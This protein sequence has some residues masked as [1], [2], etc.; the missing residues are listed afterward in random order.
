MTT[1]CSDCKGR[2]TINTTPSQEQIKIENPYV[3]IQAVKSLAKKNHSIDQI[4]FGLIARYPRH[5]KYITNSPMTHIEQHGSIFVGETE[6]FLK[7]N[8]ED[9]PIQT[10]ILCA[11]STK[12]LC[13]LVVGVGATIRPCNQLFIQ[14]I[15]KDLEEDPNKRA[16]QIVVKPSITDIS[17]VEKLFNRYSLH[18]LCYYSSS[19][20]M[21]PAHRYL[22]KLV[23]FI[24]QDFCLNANE[25]YREQTKAMFKGA[26]R[27]ITK[28]DCKR[29]IEYYLQRA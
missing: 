29:W 7:S 3:L 25:D 19:C 16:F 9:Q 2:L 20:K 4:K 28:K 23:T 21:D 14:S 5:E 12:G 18:K 24:P 22:R 13:K 26:K 27:K 8:V 10:W 11:I 6:L 17:E 1:V 15:Y